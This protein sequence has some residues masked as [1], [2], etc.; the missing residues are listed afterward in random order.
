[1]RRN[2]QPIVSAPRRGRRQLWARAVIGLVST[3]VIAT[4]VSVQA[5]PS[6]DALARLKSG[7]ARF[8]ADATEALPITAPRRAA[9]AQ[10][11]SPFATVLS[12]ADSRV[13]PE[14]VFHTGLGDLFVVRSAA[15]VTDRAVLATLEY[16]ADRLHTPLL[17]VMGHESCG[18]VK[19]ALETRETHATTPSLDYLLNAIRPAVARSSS[20]SS[21]TRLRAAILANVEETINQLLETSTTIKRLAETQ[22]I[23]LV[24]AYYELATGRVHFSEPV[25]V[26]TRPAPAAPAGRTSASPAARV[27]ASARPSSATTSSPAAEKSTIPAPLPATGSAPSTTAAKPPPAAR[28]P[29]PATH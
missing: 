12:C 29:P 13:P 21:D 16:G 27:P 11:Q 6:G 10:G 22:Q 19:A 17:V 8:V 7:N 14:V 15:H 28:V 1:M 26:L 5:D 2:S 23:L 20:Q 4:A 3:A 25:H 18:I 9:L 24:G